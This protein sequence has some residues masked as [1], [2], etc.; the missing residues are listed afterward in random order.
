MLIASFP[1]ERNV[2]FAILGYQTAD[3]EATIITIV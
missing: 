3:S 2:F 1:H